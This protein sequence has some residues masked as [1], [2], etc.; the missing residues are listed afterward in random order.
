VGRPRP[1]VVAQR[2]GRITQ[3]RQ[4]GALP[5]RVARD[6][7]AG[8]GQLGQAQRLRRFAALVG[9]DAG[10]ALGVGPGRRILGGRAEGG[11]HPVRLGEVPTVAEVSAQRTHQPY[12]HLGL[13]MMDDPIHGRPY[14]VQFRVDVGGRLGP[15][16]QLREVGRVRRP[17]R[18]RLHQV[19]RHLADRVEHRDV[20]TVPVDDRD[21]LGVDQH[22]DRRVQ[23]GQ[24]VRQL[25]Q[26]D[27]RSAAAERAEHRQ[28][29]VLVG[30]QL[31]QRPRQGGV[32]AAV[33]VRP[34]DRVGLQVGQVGQRRQDVGRFPHA[35]PGRRQL[36]RQWQ[37]V[38]P[39]AQ[40]GER[41]RVVGGEREPGPDRAGPFDQQRHRRA[42][43]DL[44][45]Q[46]AQGPQVLAL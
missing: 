19:R 36:D 35:Q 43:L 1:G 25:S 13:S 22:C 8:G 42:V 15:A 24:P 11:Q 20:G 16:E 21:E 29:A 26:V 27:H 45:G 44:G 9:R 41:G 10:T 4:G 31:A 7:E 30:P 14:V 23:V 12:V 28:Q 40:R 34:V 32:Q 5:A 37:A 3:Q 2:L 18:G 46:R 6:R 33:P 17:D 38:Q 39:P